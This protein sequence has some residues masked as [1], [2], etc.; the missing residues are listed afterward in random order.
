MNTRQY[1][2]LKK[3]TKSCKEYADITI[4]NPQ[5]PSVQFPGK[6]QE[7]REGE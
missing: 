2:Q 4:T 6:L 3:Q 7:P 1:N 5:L